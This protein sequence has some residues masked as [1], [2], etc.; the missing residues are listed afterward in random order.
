VLHVG[1]DN[2][3]LRPCGLTFYAEALMDAQRAAGH[4]VAYLFSGRYFPRLERPR[5][6]RSRRR[7][8]RTFELIGSPINTH[9]ERGTRHP[10]RDIDEP[11]G[12]AAF[13]AAL[14]EARP[15]VVHVQELLRLPSSILERAREAGVPV[16][17]TLHDYKP[18]CASVRL[19]DADGA[20]CM[21][22]E[23][24]ED[25]AR[26]CAGAPEGN[27]HL[28][29]ATLAHYRRRAKR[30]VP[31][32]E[33]LDFGR[34]APLVG[35]VNRLLVRAQPH[36]L[37]EVDVRSHG[38]EPA[39]GP[40]PDEPTLPPLDPEPFQRRRDVNVG[41]LSMCDRLV[42]PSPRVAEIYAELGVDPGRIVVQR[43]TLPHLAELAPRRGAEP[44]APL[45]FV[46]LGAA[47]SETKGSRAI[48]DAVRALEAAGR[49]GSYRLVVHGGVERSIHDEL[50]AIG[51]VEL[52]G[53][54]RPED[55]DGLLDAADVGIVPSVWEEVHG[56][57][58]IEMLA[59]GLPLIGSALGGIPEYVREGETG[60]LNR[61]ASGAELAELMAR[62]IDDPAEVERLRRSVRERRAEL[63]RPMAD[64]AAEVEALYRELTGGV[65][66]VGGEGGEG[67]EGGGGGEGG[68]R[69]LHH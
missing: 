62:A 65:G 28:I 49:G 18:L 17:M 47:A 3:V 15:D 16:V 67:G 10:E 2:A 43:L 12:D 37:P 22:R 66:G 58:G 14:R 35:T 60:W 56:F 61:S 20:R 54:Y 46:T 39:A 41:R 57:V 30:L 44:G 59:K 50:E 36:G 4:E 42:A 63:V 51:S 9:T 23:V 32:G 53:P 55:L 6:K 25:C 1:D 31:G 27:N 26:N 7:G 21:R 33:D 38:V 48:L 5:L 24:G 29:E 8:V 34:V 52:A 45:T 68:A 64:H 40:V 19:I 13:A 11:V 69:T